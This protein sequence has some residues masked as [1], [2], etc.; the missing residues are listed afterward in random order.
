MSPFVRQGVIEVGVF[1]GLILMAQAAVSLAG[2][3]GPPWY[4]IPAFVL[5]VSLRTV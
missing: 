5:G 3:E 1:T 4:L 2:G